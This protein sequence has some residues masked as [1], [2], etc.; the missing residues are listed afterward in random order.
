MS[1]VDGI[2]LFEIASDEFVHLP[3]IFMTG[4][5]DN[6]RMVSLPSRCAVITKPFAPIALLTCSRHVLKKP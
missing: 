5:A 1:G 2:P 6:E 3:F 4:Y